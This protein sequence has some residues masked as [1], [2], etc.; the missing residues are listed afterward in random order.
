MSDNETSNSEVETQESQS[1]ETNTDSN[2][3][4]SSS[5][6]DQNLKKDGIQDYQFEL[7]LNDAKEK[8]EDTVD[9]QNIKIKEVNFDDDRGTYYYEVTGFDKTNEYDVKIDAETGEILENK[10]EKED[11][12][13]VAL[14]FD[15]IKTPEEAMKDDLNQVDNGR[16]EGWELTNE[17]GRAIY[18]IALIDQDDLEIPAFKN[19]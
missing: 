5:T 11:D 1:K 18:E 7:S 10:Q 6:E 17:N 16:V 2:S 12:Q 15:Q 3:Q 8:F 4:K 19:E 13:A 14:E 9:D